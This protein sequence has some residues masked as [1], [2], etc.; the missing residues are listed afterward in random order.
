MALYIQWYLLSTLVYSR[1]YIPDDE[2]SRE[3]KSRWTKV[4]F[5]F[6][7][8]SGREAASSSHHHVEHTEG[9]KVLQQKNEILLHLEKSIS[10]L[11]M[12][13]ETLEADEEVA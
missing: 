4:S 13:T 2:N 8:T 11:M 10:D 12:M 9:D 7:W 5:T 3:N 6:A 1:V